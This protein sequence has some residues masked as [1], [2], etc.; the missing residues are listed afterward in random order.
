M[1]VPPVWEEWP[2]GAAGQEEAQFEPD[3]SPDP[4]GTPAV[5][6]PGPGLSDFEL[7]DPPPGLRGFE[8][9]EEWR[10]PGLDETTMPWDDPLWD[11]DGGGPG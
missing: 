6:D 7:G 3:L 5:P 4:P 2:S 11:P 9:P 1:I 8:E 10:D